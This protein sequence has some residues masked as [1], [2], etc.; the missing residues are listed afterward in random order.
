MDTALGGIAAFS[1]FECGA[2]QAGGYGDFIQK[3]V[4]EHDLDQGGSHDFEAVREFMF[5]ALPLFFRDAS[6]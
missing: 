1:L 3:P 6:V 5:N 2:H 4:E